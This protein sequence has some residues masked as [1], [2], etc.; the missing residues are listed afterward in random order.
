VEVAFVAQADSSSAGICSVAVTAPISVVPLL[1]G[2]FEALPFTLLIVTCALA[3]TYLL[4]LTVR[5][6][7]TRR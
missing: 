6:T 7:T 2:T 4:G 3:N 5:R 1:A